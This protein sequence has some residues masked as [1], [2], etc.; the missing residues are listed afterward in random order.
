MSEAQ[1]QHWCIT[2]R[3]HGCLEQFW[4]LSP[5]TGATK[6][7][8]SL[9][10]KTAAAQ[11]HGSRRKLKKLRKGSYVTPHKADALSFAVPWSTADL[12]YAGGPDG[13]PPRKLKFKGKPPRDHKIYLYRVK[14]PSKKAATNTGAEYDWNRT[15]T[16]AADV[17]LVATIP[18]WKRA[19][20]E[21]RASG[22]AC[23]SFETE[24]QKIAEAAGHWRKL[25]PGQVGHDQGGN[26]QE[27]RTWVAKN[28]LR[29][30]V[31]LKK[32]QADFAKTVLKNPTKGYIAAHG[33]GTGKTISAIA[34]FEQMKELADEFCRRVFAPLY[35]GDTGK[36]TTHVELEVDVVKEHNWDSDDEGEE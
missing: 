30:F 26:E 32:H 5:I 29:K 20:L 22:V 19:L 4:F 25:P 31:K 27:G 18:S 9:A 13:R 14:A 3:K 28:R 15:I 12:V 36:H 23:A 10:E 16:E 6:L 17:E 33:T 21:K 11:Y 7:N 1:T 35:G 2:H 34:T 8:L 24:F